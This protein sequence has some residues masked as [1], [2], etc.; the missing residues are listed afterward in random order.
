MILQW[1]HVYTS[2]HWAQKDFFLK[3][4]NPEEMYYVS[5]KILSSKTVFNIDNNMKI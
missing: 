3:N 1:L 4:L 5:S 2:K